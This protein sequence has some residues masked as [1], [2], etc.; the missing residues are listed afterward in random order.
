MPNGVVDQ[1]TYNNVNQLTKETEDGP[2]NTPISEYD[3]TYRPDG[4]E[5][6][7]TEDFWF[8]DNGQ[9]VEVTNNIAYTYDALDRLTDEAFVTNAE[10]ILGLDPSLPSDVRQWESFNDQYFYD[11]DSNQVE[12]TTELAGTQTPDETITSTYDAND[13][14]LQQV[15]TTA[16]GSTTTNFSY[17]NTEQTA[18]TVYSGTP[19]ALGT[20][21][22]SQQC[23]YDLQ[24]RMTGVTITTY[25]NGAT[26]E[27][28]QLTY[29]YDDNGNRISAL[30][31]IDT[32][33]DGTWDSQMLTEYLNDDNNLT[34]YS[35]VVRETQSDA[36]NGQVQQ[37]V[38]YA[39]GPRQVSQTMTTYTNGQPGTPSTLHFGYD[40]HGSVRV[41]FSAGGVLATV[42]GIRQLFNFDAYGNA[43]GFTLQLA[44]TT[45]LYSGQQTDIATGLQYLRARYYNSSTGAF[46]SLDSYKGD[47]TT[48]IS[49]NKYVY[50]TSDPVNGI[51]PSG[52]AVY[53]VER[54]L[55][56]KFG[57]LAWKA[58]FGHGF[59]LFTDPKNDTGKGDPYT[60]GATITDSFSFH[61]YIWSYW[62]EESR[63][64]ASGAYGVPG[65]P[66]RVWERHPDDMTTKARGIPYRTFLV[67]TDPVAQDTLLN[68]INGW[69]RSM[70]VGYEL[71]DPKP[72]TS[73]TDPDNEI[74]SLA[75]V[76]APTD[77]VYYS[78]L[79]QNCVWWATIMLKQ[80][81]I[82]VPATV[83]RA[84]ETF[85]GGTTGGAAV[86]KGDRSASD[87][88]TI[89]SPSAWYRASIWG[90][91]GGYTSVGSYV[92][93]AA[94]S[95][96][97]YIGSWFG[98]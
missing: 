15:D 40:G 38:E 6:T 39:I 9:N 69:I 65:V 52:D 25:T 70:P 74:G 81:K 62:S 76:A 98:T 55:S 49:L 30:D 14:L 75:H 84:I 79:E 68:Y 87:V 22:S 2:G 27:I 46:E 28:E 10:R 58:T 29:G 56:M 61:P 80:S 54:R 37:V 51:D 32:N 12:K 45:L 88:G 23:Q 73:G 48:P 44:A 36:T 89:A 93:S 66:G 18:E 57:D 96:G 59:L 41:L 91:V 60:S 5:A 85:E 3:Y 7:A 13:R 71:G 95:V 77:A 83:D 47:Q 1:F 78:L 20:I 86:I 35:Q 90:V 50:A 67:T 21:Q 42:G 92:S 64:I 63:N 94:A 24:G 11:L 53:F 72:D 97:S 4:L 31:Q 33:A 34:G 19:S 82:D 16:S 43:V 8:A 26:S 17:D